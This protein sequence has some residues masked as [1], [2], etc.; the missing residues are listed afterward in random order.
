MYQSEREALNRQQQIKSRKAE[1]FN[2][3]DYK[4]T[5]T[6]AATALQAEMIELAQE[7]V[8]LQ[9]QKHSPNADEQAQ[10][11]QQQH[12]QTVKEKEIQLNRYK[13][14]LNA[15][16]QTRQA[17]A[18]YLPPEHSTQTGLSEQGFK[19]M[20]ELESYLAKENANNPTPQ[21][22]KID[23]QLDYYNQALNSGD[24]KS[25]K[26]YRD[27]LVANHPDLT[28]ELPEVD[29]PNQFRTS[30]AKATEIR[31]QARAEREKLH[32]SPDT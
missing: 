3:P 16:E 4:R 24:L 32:P 8:A 17:L 27:M 11:T 12:T 13:Q 29:V 5:G 6:P 7:S 14:M 22:Q 21:Q 28:G 23:L 31:D 25:A 1:I 19:E 2:N 18:H 26:H 10:L 20:A 9:S 30:D 15:P